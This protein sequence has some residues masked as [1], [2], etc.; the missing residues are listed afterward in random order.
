[1]QAEA[2]FTK[3]GGGAAATEE[4]IKDCKV[5]KKFHL[6]DVGCSTGRT[7][8]ML[9]KKF[10][11]KVK[12]VDISERMIERANEK[13]KKMKLEELVEFG[14]ASAEKLLFD[15]ETFD[16]VFSES[17][18]AFVENKPKAVKEYVRVLKKSGFVWINEVTWMKENP[19]KEIADYVVKAMGGVKPESFDYWE[20]LLQDAGLKD[21]KA[22]MAK[23]GIINQAISEAKGSSF[24]EAFIGMC[25]IVKLY[26]TN[27]VYRRGINKL[28]R[29]AIRIPR[30][31][32]AYLGYGIYFGRK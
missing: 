16:V 17:V 29:D 23:I 19:S 12:G 30:N 27:G 28:M 24:M 1:M 13:V 8:C 2:G 6:L 26:F 32:L 18:T 14:V 25:R 9:A 10:G 7:S 22:R 31:L 3:Q 21:V 4:M 5:N 15:N 20:K 11:C